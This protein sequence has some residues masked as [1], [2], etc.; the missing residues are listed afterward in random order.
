[1]EAGTGEERMLG[2]C[3]HRASQMARVE[4]LLPGAHSTDCRVGERTLC[5]KPGDGS[6]K[7]AMTWVEGMERDGARGEGAGGRRAV[8][9]ED[10]KAQQTLTQASLPHTE[11][12]I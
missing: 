12:S 3:S 4:P 2:H 11:L 7:G 5:L 8:S 9:L 10:G 6:G 1:V